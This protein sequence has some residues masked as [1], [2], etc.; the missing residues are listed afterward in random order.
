MIATARAP[1]D[2]LLELAHGAD[3]DDIAAKVVARERLSLDDGL[4]LYRSPHVHAVGALAN[5]VRERMHGDRAF[6]NVNQHVN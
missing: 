4:A 6:F 5:F 3:L 1:L 2:A